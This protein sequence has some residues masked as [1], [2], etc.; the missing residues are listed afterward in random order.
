MT[1]SSWTGSRA[2]WSHRPSGSSRGRSA[3]RGLA[4]RERALARAELFAG[5]PKRQLRAIAGAS[6]LTEYR[7]GRTVVEE[8][9][10]G[11][12]FF[13]IVEGRAKVLKG[14]RTVARLKPGD[15][16]GEMS[17]LDGAPRA[18]TVVAETDATFLTLSSKGLS[19][20][21]SR[22]PTLAMRMLKEM[23]RRLRA[24]EK[25]LVG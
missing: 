5:L 1:P 17:V 12:V 21:L 16:F 4:E 6:G 15:F 2:Q 18:A 14:R 23:A 8:G 10:R 13:V 19:E 7:E 24:L 20:V 25:P 11:A 22:E 3:R 9:D